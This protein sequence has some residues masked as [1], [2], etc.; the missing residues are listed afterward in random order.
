MMIG[1]T[2]DWKGICEKGGQDKEGGIKG[3]DKEAGIKRK[4]WHCSSNFK[5]HVLA[6][7]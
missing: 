5:A 4:K 6:T 2:R 3:R 7:E 1:K